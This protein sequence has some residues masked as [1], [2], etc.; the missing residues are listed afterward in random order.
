MS[1]DINDFARE[2][3]YNTR[4]HY[5]NPNR[6]TEL[7]AI[8]TALSSDPTT[9]DTTIQTPPAGLI[10]GS[11][12]NTKFTNDILLVVNQGKCG[13]LTPSAMSNAITSALSTFIPPVNTTAPAVSPTGP[14]ANGATLTVTNSN[15]NFVPTSYEYVWR[16]DSVPI[17]GAGGS[18]SSYVTVAADATH[19][20]TCLVIATNAA[21]S[22][23][24]P[25]SNAVSVT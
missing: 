2:V 12:L 19:S 15:W 22:T 4:I 23:N 25:V 20:I 7:N 24:A 6:A 13:R 18:G 10:P 17:G 5:G 1:F 14:V 11:V 8:A 16:R 3:A 9:Y 21:G